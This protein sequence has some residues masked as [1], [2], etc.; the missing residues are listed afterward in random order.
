[1]IAAAG[2]A[3]LLPRIA[4][5]ATPADLRSDIAILREALKLHPGL[6][7]YATPAQVAARIDAL[8]PAFV[9]APT[10]EARYLLL[11]RFLA[12]IRCGH[13]YCNFFNQTRPVAQ[14]LFDRPTRLP[15]RFRWIGGRMIVVGDPEQLGLPPGTEVTDVN[16][17]APSAMLSRLL[18]YARADGGNDGKRVA[19]MEMTGGDTIEYFDVFHGLTYGAPAGGAHRLTVRPPADPRMPPFMP[20]LSRPIASSTHRSA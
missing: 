7:R 14:A 12:T 3:L 16:G 19:L 20:R 13:S 10:L 6:H 4:A 1:M 8:E 18:P 2:A 5:A 9:A 15:F 11:S 17:V